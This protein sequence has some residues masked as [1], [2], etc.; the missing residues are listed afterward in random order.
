MLPLNEDFLLNISV[1]IA[2]LIIIF[3]KVA[4][5]LKEVKPNGGK[6]LADSIK[7][8]ESNMLWMSIF[9]HLYDHPLFRTD[10]FGN[11]I[12]INN[13]FSIMAGASF[14][15]VKDKRWFSLVSEDDRARIKEEWKEAVEDKRLFDVVYWIH[16]TPNKKIFK[17]REIAYPNIV[18]GELQ[19]YMGTINI[20]EEKDG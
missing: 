13:S 20:L 17:V 18:L 7:R 3:R 9:Q 12:W 5:I 1:L 2:G 8:I 6:S 15:E 19:G 16:N 10:K 14:E 11:Y 4:L